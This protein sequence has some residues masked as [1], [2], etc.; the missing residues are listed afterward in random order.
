[1]RISEYFRTVEGF[2]SLT[3]AAADR[4][5]EFIDMEWYRAGEHIVRRGAVADAMYI[6]VDG[7]VSV[8]VVDEN[9]SCQFVAHLGP[10]SIFGEMALLTGEL[11]SA[12][13]VAGSDCRCLRIPAR[14]VDELLEEHPEVAGFLTAILG[15]RLLQAGGIRQV[16]KYRLVG[17]LGRGGMGRVY[18]GL[19]PQ[20]QRPVAVKMLSHTLIYRRHF[21]E[22]FRN[23]ARIIAGLR[24][25]NI[26]DIYDVEEAYATIFIIMEKLTGL[27]LE[28][29]LREQGRI[30]PSLVRRILRDVAGALEYA[31]QHGIVHR[32]VKP[33]NIFINGG[34]VIKLT[35][36]GIAAVAG[37]EEKMGDDTG[38]YL[39]T[40]IYS[41]PEHALGIPV[42][43]RSDIYALG[44][45]AY[46]LL[47]GSVPFEGDGA[48]AVLLKHV[49]EPMPSPRSFDPTIPHDLDEFVRRACAKRPEDRYQHCREIV[50]LFD[51]FH[52]R[53]TLPQQVRIRTLTFIYSPEAESEVNRLSASI[54][55]MATGING[56]VTRIT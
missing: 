53:T 21:A 42:D 7:H 45:V 34:G 16:G 9:G 11:R 26:V 47:T 30:E 52:R 54:E 12:D 10:K 28:Q 31:H 18:E 1:M 43:R 48:T 24:H 46:E 39:G 15:E 35:D 36:F 44:V 41:S 13:V 6:V 40:P 29:I 17:E 50:E 4:L 51:T 3:P 14:V 5:A 23:E 56:L 20:L 8:H 22:R 32:D 55:A 19:H 2:L 27:D 37:V 25:P 49:H 33:S 38:L